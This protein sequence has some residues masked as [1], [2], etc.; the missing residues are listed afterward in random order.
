MDKN[1]YLIHQEIAY[2]EGALDIPLMFVKK[3]RTTGQ[4]DIAKLFLC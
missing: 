1:I 4:K 3:K 2:R